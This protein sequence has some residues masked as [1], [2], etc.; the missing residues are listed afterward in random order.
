MV[1]ALVSCRLF[2]L[3][4]ANR[5]AKC[6]TVQLDTFITFIQQVLINDIYDAL[7]PGR[8]NVFSNA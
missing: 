5:D 7:K 6:L 1:F 3:E 2:C 4:C 8:I